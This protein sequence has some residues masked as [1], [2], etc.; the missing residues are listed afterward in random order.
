MVDEASAA[1]I[2]TYGATILPFGDSFYD[3]PERETARQ[4]VNEWIRTIGRFDDV[5]DLD[6]ALRGTEKP[7]RLL[8]EACHGGHLHR[9][10]QGHQL[11]GE[12]IGLLM[13]A[14]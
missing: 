11:I 2:R 10:E 1:G 14:R 9:N 13:V 3:M 7:S 12:S 5:I 4:T 6:E 8:D